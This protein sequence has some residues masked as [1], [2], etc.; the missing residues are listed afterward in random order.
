MNFQ[1]KRFL[2]PII[3]GLFILFLG[4]SSDA[5]DGNTGAPFDGT[6]SNC[7]SGG[8]YDGTVSISGF[9]SS[10]TPNTTYTITLTANATTGNPLKGG[11][12]LVC[13]NASNQNAGTLTAGGDSGISSFNSR[14]YIDHRGAKSYSGN[15]VSWTFSWKAPNGPNG[16][17]IT[18]YFTTNMANGNGSSSGDKILKDNQSGT[19]V[20]GGNPLSVLISSK[21]NVSC[22]GGS[23]GEATATATGGTSPYTFT[24]SNGASGNTASLLTAGSYTVTVTD[25]VNA[26][27][28]A[29]TTIT[30]PTVLISSLNVTKNVSC[31]GGKDGSILATGSGGTG[32]YNFVYSSGSPNN[33]FAGSYTVTVS[34]ANNCT[35]SSS[36]I[37]TQADSF[38]ITT[39]IFESPSCPLDSNGQI[40]ISVTGA[41]PPYKYLWSTGEVSNQISKKKV[42]NY[43][44]TISDNKNCSTVRGYE[45]KSSD[46]Q[47]PFLMA[48]NGKAYLNTIGKSVPKI[49][50]Y[51]VSN[52]DNCDPSPALSINI[53]TFRCNHVGKRNYIISS[54][55][56]SGNKALDTIEIEVLDTIKPVLHIWKDTI[57]R[58]CDVV[59]PSFNTTDNCSISEFKKISGPDAGSVFQT[60]VTIMKYSA[61][62]PSNNE[63]VDSFKVTVISPLHYSVDSMYFNYCKGDT[64]FTILRISHD[65]HLPMK[66]YYLNDTT[67][68]LL[69]SNFTI[70]TTNIDTVQF[71]LTEESGCNVAYQKEIQYPGL[72]LVLDSVHLKD[73]S[74]TND[75]M[76]EV[77][78]SGNADSISWYDAKNNTYVNS[79]GLNL[80]A[81][82]YLVKA[83]KGPCEFIYG[84]YNIKTVVSTANPEKLYLKA[85][86]IPF[87]DEITVVSDVK[88]ELE[89]VL[90]NAQ[91][92]VVEKGKFKLQF[93]LS[94]SQ[95]NAGMYF[96]RCSG[97]NKSNTMRL[98]KI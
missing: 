84:P 1:D 23:D 24:W 55:D 40:K 53:D 7:H 4:S 66:F 96:I 74:G 83:Y 28:T 87:S 30:Q 70:A 54:T 32:P 14:T 9:P 26:S 88:S 86:P 68:V 51:I 46:S 25:N 52:T 34:D 3:F 79:T 95:L 27:S 72:P 81:G 44:V 45:L 63:T 10:I 17:V 13:V 39:T 31:Y 92:N 71:K 58:R 89:Y 43:K 49:S 80:I 98:I 16:A 20:G 15:S 35:S 36:V 69:D 78:I 61:K 93:N 38:A 21:K 67:K 73:A 41:T 11:F 82:D 22:N 64:A 42:G 47:V 97:I 12:Q 85:Y 50:D 59:V 37:V 90:L 19:I 5:P 62:D 6:C 60:G 77:F 91:G 2:I 94:T 75:G 56:I 8:S 33:L 18:M 76:I 65:L 48:K 29:S 57:I